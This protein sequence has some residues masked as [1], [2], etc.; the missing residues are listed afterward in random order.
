M[1]IAASYENVKYSNS[2]SCET[3]SKKSFAFFNCE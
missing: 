2:D 1:S 3:K